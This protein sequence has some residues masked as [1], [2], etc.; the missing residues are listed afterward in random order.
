[1]EPSTIWTIATLCIGMLIVIGGILAL[2]LHAFLALTFA[3][4]VVAIMTPQSAT[5]HYEISNSATRVTYTEDVEYDR[6]DLDGSLTPATNVL[7]GIP[8]KDQFG[9][10]REY[11]LIRRMG[12]VYKVII[13]RIDPVDGLGS[14]TGTDPVA[15]ALVMVVVDHPA[16]NRP[17]VGDFVIEPHLYA[18]AVKESRQT[19]ASRVASGFG[20]TAGKIGI[21]IAMASII[22]KCLLD[23]GAADR[24][25]RTALAKFGEKFAPLSFVFSGFLLGVPVFFDT[26]FYLM[27]PLGKAMQLRTGRNYLLFVLTI[28]A[29]ATMAHSLVPPTPGPLVVAEELGVDIGM[30]ILAGCCVGFFTAGFGYL[31]A[32]MFA[33]K[34]WTLPLRETSDF[35][36]KDLETLSNR[37]ESELPPFWLSILPIVLPVVLIAGYSVI[38]ALEVEMSPTVSKIAATLG[39]KNIALIISA[40]IAMFTLI[41]SRG[42]SRK[43]LA[44]AVGASL[45]SGGIIILIT[46]AGGAFGKTLQATGV[47]TLI[48]DLSVTSPAMIITM[49]WLITA[50]IRT[51]QGSATVAMMTAVGILGGLA[52]SGTLPFHP[53]YLALAIG[54]GSKPIA[55]MNDSGFWVITRM[56]GMTEGEG[57]KYITPMTTLMGV[58]GLVVTIAGAILFPMV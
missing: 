1:M 41:R 53:V 4:L 35:S 33:N 16:G 29:G 38:K 32:S 21:L 12:D 30:M 27:I 6:A 7:V 2:R 45:A 48:Q 39:D 14:N 8:D 51:A 22:G 58:V 23:S 36:L 17:Q 3:A 37:D 44:D 40:V 46:S 19:V 9:F 26:V 43:E 42:L 24:I 34:I 20:T 13:P 11:M 31:Y 49:A 47:A 56:S 10:D 50:A 57:L 18:S 52:Q 28:V 55:W 54:C 15:T 25:V 5:Q